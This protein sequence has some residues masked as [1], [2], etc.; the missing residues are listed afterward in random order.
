MVQRSTQWPYMRC[1]L[2]NSS[3]VVARAVTHATDVSTGCNMRQI[4]GISVH[5]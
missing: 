5:I 2:N 3:Y 4:E 1:F